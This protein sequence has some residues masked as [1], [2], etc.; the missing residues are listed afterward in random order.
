M[1]PSA[2]FP[3]ALKGGTAPQT[4]WAFFSKITTHWWQVNMFLIGSILRNL[5]TAQ[6]FELK[7]LLIY[8]SKRGKNGFSRIV[9][10][11][12]TTMVSTEIKVVVQLLGLLLI[13][14]ANLPSFNMI[15]FG[16][17][18]QTFIYFLQK[19]SLF[20]CIKCVILQK[21]FLFCFCMISFFFHLFKLHVFPS[22]TYLP[23]CLQIKFVKWKHMSK[24]A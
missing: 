8:G 16:N 18:G 10:G 14:F 3:H 24:A 23:T 20:F 9:Y 17:I 15:S 2:P 22:P 13:N 4:V 1:G 11:N 19:I 12:F 5:T 21:I 7:W 6:E